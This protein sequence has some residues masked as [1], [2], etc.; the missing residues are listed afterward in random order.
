ML[1]L[2]GLVG[3]GWGQLWTARRPLRLLGSYA[4]AVTVHG[5]W[6]AA[7]VGAVLLSASAYA[8][9]GDAF[10]L[11]PLGLGMLTLIGLLGLVTVTSIFALPLAGRRLA[12]GAERLQ[13]TTVPSDEVPAPVSSGLSVP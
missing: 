7:A 5:L 2:G 4:A 9:E 6:N 10:W 13:R 11:A 8:H 3:W 12:A 1:E